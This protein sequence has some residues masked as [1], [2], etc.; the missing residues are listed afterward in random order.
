MAEVKQQPNDVPVKPRLKM[1]RIQFKGKGTYTPPPAP[2]KS[3]ES[4]KEE[5]PNGQ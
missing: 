2:Q 5:D 3:D 1:P 4:M